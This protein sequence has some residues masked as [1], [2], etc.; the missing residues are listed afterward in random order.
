MAQK[1]TLEKMSKKLLIIIATLILAYP[2]GILLVWFWTKWPNWVKVLLTLPLMAAIL[3]VIISL[4]LGIAFVSIWQ[5]VEGNLEKESN[6]AP[7]P[8]PIEESVVY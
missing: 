1:D 3:L 2:I 8:L 7:T 4:G 5:R 6:Q